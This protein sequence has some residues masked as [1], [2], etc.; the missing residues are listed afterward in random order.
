MS[1]FGLSLCRPN[2]L[3][4]E[5]E[6]GH[7]EL[8]LRGT[9]CNNANAAAAGSPAAHSNRHSTAAAALLI[10]KQRWDEVRKW[11]MA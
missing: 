10:T 2:R 7:C 6:R 3:Q 9:P 1:S 4:R 5:H 8:R 11:L